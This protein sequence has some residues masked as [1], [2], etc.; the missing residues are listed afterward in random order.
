MTVAYVYNIRKAF[1]TATAVATAVLYFV[2]GTHNESSSRR[3]I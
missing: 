1:E 3:N 2:S